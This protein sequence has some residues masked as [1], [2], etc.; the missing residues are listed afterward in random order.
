MTVTPQSFIQG[1]R[2]LAL[3]VTLI[4]TAHEGRWAGLTATAVCSVSAEPP[5]L[6]A[7]IN[8]QAETHRLIAGAARLRSTCWPPR[9]SASPRSSRA[10]AGSTATTASTRPSGAP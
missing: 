6:L 1:M 3:G 4:T 7:C 5:Q 2:Q 9:S 10:P 8:R